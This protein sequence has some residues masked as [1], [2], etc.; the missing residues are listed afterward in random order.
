M[1]EEQAVNLIRNSLLVAGQEMGAEGDH[2]PVIK[3]TVLDL[4]K[5]RENSHIEQNV[6][7][8]V[9]RQYEILIHELEA[10]CGEAPDPAKK[11]IRAT[12]VALREICKASF[13]PVDDKNIP[14]SAADLPVYLK[15][16]KSIID[17]LEDTDNV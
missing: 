16:A 12:V 2:W 5:D 14:I 4:M 8:E 10:L 17:T 7:E 6:L 13:T 11:E 9:Q 15:R 1:T 3:A